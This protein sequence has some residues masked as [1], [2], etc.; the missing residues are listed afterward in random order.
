[1]KE[2]TKRTYIKIFQYALLIVV[3]IFM[4]FPIFWVFSNSLKTLNGISEYPPQFF[5][6]N[7]QWDNYV[8]V[9]RQT[10]R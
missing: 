9:F 7:P 4:F 10:N 2:H 3:G 8:E 1:M 5:P 6:K